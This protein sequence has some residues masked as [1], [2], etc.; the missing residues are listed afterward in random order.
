MSNPIHKQVLNEVADAVRRLDLFAQNEVVVRR[1]PW[2]KTGDGNVIIHKG[3]TVFPAGEREAPG[4]NARE[5]IGYD[6]GIMVCVGMVPAQDEQIEKLAHCREVIRREVYHN[7]LTVSTNQA[8]GIVL[9]LQT[10]VVTNQTNLPKEAD[11]YECE[12]MT[13]R[14]W[15][16]EPRTNLGV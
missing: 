7:V 6:V 4:T 10:K 3:I 1:R 12:L 16:R 9:Y 2:H 8:S 15:V 14:C 13:I 11:R 5:D